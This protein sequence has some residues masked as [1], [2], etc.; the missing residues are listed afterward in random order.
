MSSLCWAQWLVPVIL[1]LAKLRQEN[2]E[3]EANLGN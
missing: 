3:F 2:F 1:G